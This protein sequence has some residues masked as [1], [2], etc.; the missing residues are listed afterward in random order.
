MVKGVLCV[1]YAMKMYTSKSIKKEPGLPHEDVACPFLFSVC[2]LFLSK[3]IH[4]FKVASS[5][6]KSIKFLGYAGPWV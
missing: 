5:T 4:S 2:K 1:N 6:R 3:S